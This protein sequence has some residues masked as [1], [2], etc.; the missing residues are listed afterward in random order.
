MRMKRFHVHVHVDD[1]AKSI[2]FYEALFGAAPSV[3][4]HD[5]AKWLLDEPQVNF[6]ISTGARQPGIA[7]LGLQVDD[8]K[9]LDQIE[10]R[11]GAAELG[12]HAEPDATCCYAR[13]N[14]HWFT[15]PQGVVWE[16]FETFGS[17]ESLQ[18]G[19]RAACDTRTG[20][21]A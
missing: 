2:L 20:C 21:C 11:G 16:M 15:D 13:S 14:K 4:K 17:A 12:G 7:H 18:S 6:A 10:A 9:E 8:G 5:Y 3:R 1:L 19:Q